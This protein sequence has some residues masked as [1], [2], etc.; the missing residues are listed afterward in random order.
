MKHRQ[1]GFL[2]LL[3]CLWSF[4]SSALAQDGKALFVKL[5][6]ATCHGPDGKGMFRTRTKESFTIKKETLGALRKAGV[7]Q[8]VVKK[9]TPLVKKRFSKEKKIVKALNK[10]LGTKAT[11]RYKTTILDLTRKIKYRKGDP[12][13]AFAAYPKLAGNRE[14][15]LYTQMKDILEGRRKNGNTDAMRGILPFLQ[16]NKITDEDLRSIAKYLSQVE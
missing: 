1:I 14:I 4:G 9:L 13:K 2:I 3:F 11:K 15:Y 12:I 8:R 6:C 16:T 5:T 10:E 7:P